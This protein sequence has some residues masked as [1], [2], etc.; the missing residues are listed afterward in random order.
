VDNGVRPLLIHCADDLSLAWTKRGDGPEGP[1]FKTATN[2]YMYVTDRGPLRNRGGRTF[3]DQPA[4]LDGQHTSL[5][6][7]K[8]GGNFDP[9]PLAHL[10]FAWML[11]NETNLTLNVLGPM[12]I[13]DL[14]FSGARIATITG[15]EELVL[16][17]EQQKA[18]VGFVAGGG[19]LIVDAAGGSRQFATSAQRVLRKMFPRGVATRGLRRMDLAEPIY[20]LEGYEIDKVSYRRTTRRRLGGS[21]RPMLRS[22]SLNGRVRVV[23]SSEDITSGL[24]GAPA[25]GC[26]GYSGLSAYQLM[27]NIVL[28]AAP[29][30]P[31]R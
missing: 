1:A 24:L 23:F 30:S 6:K 8:H 19:T 12:K 27:R 5:A 18:L 16:S 25:F 4:Y 11:G 26:D 28:Q 20:R 10:R 29:K 15:T 2:V 7:L 3:P 21:H 13:T 9:E 22:I 17:D 31:N 14:S